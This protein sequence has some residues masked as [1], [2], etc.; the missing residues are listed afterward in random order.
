MLPFESEKIPR[1]ESAV[2]RR[3]REA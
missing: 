3:T 1:R 2:S